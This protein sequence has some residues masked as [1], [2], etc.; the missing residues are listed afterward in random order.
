MLKYQP[1]PTEEIEDIIIGM[2]DLV[3]ELRE[4]RRENAEL[5]EFKDKYD[6]AVYQRFKDSQQHSANMLKLALAMGERE[7]I[8]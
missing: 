7:T 1:M 4:L 8:K 6:E 5:R 3:I 2:A